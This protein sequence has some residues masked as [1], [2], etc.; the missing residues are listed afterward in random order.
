MGPRY[1]VLATLKE[2]DFSESD[3]SDFEAGAGASAVAC[4]VRKRSLSPRGNLN[5]KR[6]RVS[7]LHAGSDGMTVE[8]H[9]GNQVNENDVVSE[10]QPPEV[11]E[12]PQRRDSMDSASTVRLLHDIDEFLEPALTLDYENVRIRARLRKPHEV[13]LVLETVQAIID[14]KVRCVFSI[15]TFGCL[16]L[17][18]FVS[19]YVSAH[20]I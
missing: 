20:R 5:S 4:I 17:T 3:E 10:G 13:R 6:A 15:N 19:F 1:A 16:R 2:E 7:P 18:M 14:E 9:I 12:D 11:L 8:T